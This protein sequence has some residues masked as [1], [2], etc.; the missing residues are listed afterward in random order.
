M[1]HAIKCVVLI[2]LIDY[3]LAHEMILARFESVNTKIID[4]YIYI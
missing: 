4:V 2:P 1:W 3:L